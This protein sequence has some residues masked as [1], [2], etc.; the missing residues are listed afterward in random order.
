[1]ANER[2]IGGWFDSFVGIRGRL[3]S[4]GEIDAARAAVESTKPIESGLDLHRPV[5]DF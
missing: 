5:E 2:R 3:I 1:M 4:W